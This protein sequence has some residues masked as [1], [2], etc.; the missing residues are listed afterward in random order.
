[1]DNSR[2]N[3]KINFIE[4]NTKVIGEIHSESDFRID[5][6]LEGIVQTTGR[7]VVGQEGKIKGKI[8]CTN[9]DIMGTF[10]GTIEA[11]NL[12]SSKDE[13]VIDGKIVGKL[14]VEAGA[15]LNA[16]CLM[17]KPS[18]PYSP[19]MKKNLK[20]CV[21]PTSSVGCPYAL[22]AQLGVTILCFCPSRSMAR[23]Q[24]S[25]R[26]NLDIDLC[27]AWSFRF[28]NHFVPTTQNAQS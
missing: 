7:V 1:M 16:Q 20:N 15:M 2:N 11:S 22:C 14:A 23:F 5:G 19:P 27:S 12:L 10:E 18:N 25:N 4:P 13:G 21:N 26:S 17:K 3:I 6:T 9:A 24:L 8:I 28:H